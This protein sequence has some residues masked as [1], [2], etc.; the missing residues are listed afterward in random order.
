[1]INRWSPEETGESTGKASASS[2][3][4]V[5]SDEPEVQTGLTP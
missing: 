4:E 2:D 1:M 5:D 3:S